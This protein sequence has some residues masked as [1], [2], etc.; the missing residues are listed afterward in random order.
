MVVVMS[1][2]WGGKLRIWELLCRSFRPGCED[3]GGML[4]IWGLSCRSFRSE[5]GCV[6]AVLGRE[7]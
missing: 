1:Q 3:M 7:A 5:G 2:F 4:R 6:V